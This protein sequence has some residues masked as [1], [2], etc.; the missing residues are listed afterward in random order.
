ME[1][2]PPRISVIIVN[3]N[4]LPYIDTCLGSVLQQDFAGYEVIFVDNA[5]TDGSAD[6]V[7]NEFQSVR[8]IRNKQ[9]I[10]FSAGNNIGI[11]H[12]CGD[13]V[14]LLNSD[15]EVGPG[16]MQAMLSCMQSRPDAGAATCKLVLPDGS[17]D[18]ACHRGFPTPWAA[19]TYFLGLEKM[20]PRFP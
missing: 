2:Q 10:G 18:P 20:F 7:K 3:F 16:T 4:G 9:N 14:L 13:Y 11:R 19:L 12:A 17:L 8:V 6:M 15:T 1:K 5:S